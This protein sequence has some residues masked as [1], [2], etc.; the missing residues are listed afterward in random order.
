MTAADGAEE[1]YTTA[2]NDTRTEGPE[3]AV[4]MDRG[5]QAAWADHPRRR[6]VDNRGS[7]ADKVER[8]TAHVMELVSA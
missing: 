6:V 8:A 1:Y 4:A 3:Q 5:V 7:F 2:N